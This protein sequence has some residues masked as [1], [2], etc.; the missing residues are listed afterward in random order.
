MKIN[1]IAA[2]AGEKRVIGK[3]GGMPWHIPE[4]LKHFRRLTEGRPVI[5]GRKTYESIGKPLPHRTNI[6]IS[7]NMMNDIDRVLVAHTLS[8]ALA[9]ARISPGNEEVFILGGQRVFE[10]ALMQA[11]RLYLTQIDLEVEGDTF[12]PPYKHLFKT[13][14]SSDA[15]YSNGYYI[16]FE[17]L[18][19]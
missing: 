5:M 13:I 10:E 16:R 11:D 18:E 1:L 4:D 17:T 9:K 15:Q 7:K 14:E 12:F 2:I 19:R 6:V 3:D 8:D